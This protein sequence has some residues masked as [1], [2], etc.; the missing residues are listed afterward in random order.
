MTAIDEHS[1]EKK[2]HQF[3]ALATLAALSRRIRIAAMT[4]APAAKTA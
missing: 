2:S 4:E 3:F 1:A